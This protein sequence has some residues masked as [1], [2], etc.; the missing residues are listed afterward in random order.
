MIAYLSDT[1]N[2]TR[3][4]LNLIKNFSKV[5][6]YKISSNKSV[7][8]SSTQRIKRQRKKLGKQ[9]PSQYSQII[10]NNLLCL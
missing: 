9:H 6:E 3:E 8:F 4:L 10:L 7:A 5:A 1:Q 2:S